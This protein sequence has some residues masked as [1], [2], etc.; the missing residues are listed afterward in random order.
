MAR[1]KVTFNGFDRLAESI[2]KAGGELKPAVDEALTE[3]AKIIQSNLVKAAQPYSNKGGGRSTKNG[4]HGYATPEMYKAIKRT[5][6]VYWRGSVAEV[7][8]G[9]DLQKKGGWNS[10]FVMYGTPK[11]SKDQKIYNAIRGQKTKHSIEDAQ[12]KIMK[13]HLQ[14]A[15]KGE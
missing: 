3:T 14:L 7:S 6:N 5:I 11:Y 4:G 10:I 2:D 15:Q 1:M 9:F 12:R 13:K 8:V